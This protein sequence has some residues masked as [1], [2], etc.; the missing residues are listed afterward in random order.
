M[1]GSDC[2][3]DVVTCAAMVTRRH[4][5][6]LDQRNGSICLTSQTESHGFVEFTD[7]YYLIMESRVSQK[8]KCSHLLGSFRLN[9]GENLNRFGSQVLENKLSL[10][11]IKSLQFWDL[12]IHYQNLEFLFIELQN[13][14]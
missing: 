5:Y 2:V 9:F 13:N 8:P 12:E 7:W 1:Q 10:K 3:E 6:H 14:A 11:K 4:R